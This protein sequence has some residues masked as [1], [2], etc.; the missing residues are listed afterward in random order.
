MIVAANLSLGEEEKLLRVLREHKTTIGWTIADIKGISSAKCMHQIHLEDEA[1]PTRDAQRRFNPHMKEVVKKEVLK[2]LDVGII[3]PIS[4]SQWVSPIQVV[5]KKSGIT[6]VK[7]E[8]EE[9]IPTRLTTGWRVCIDYRRLNKVTRKDHFPLPFIDQM[10]ER[11]AGH[12]YYCFLDGY[13]GYN[14]IA[15]APEDQDKTTFKC[16][17]GTFAYRRM[18]FGLCNA[19][20]TFQRCMMSIFSDMVEKFIEVF[21]DDFSVFGSN[22]DECLYHLKVS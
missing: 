16:P 10:L 22:F 7:N 13:S 14:Q 9:L 15:I 12:S 11:L 1:K 3:Y 17:F 8:E 19:P 20:A 4:D 6:V 18:P 5:S 21:M 2:L